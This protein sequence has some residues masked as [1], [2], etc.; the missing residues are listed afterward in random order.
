MI[1]LYLACDSRDLLSSKREFE[2]IHKKQT[3][4]SWLPLSGEVISLNDHN[5]IN[6]YED[7]ESKAY[8]RVSGWFIYKG[9]LNDTESLFIDLIKNNSEALK[10]ISGGVFAALFSLGN[11]YFIFN[12]PM[13]LSN[14]FY[15]NDGANIY[16]SPT[17]TVFERGDFFLQNDPLTTSILHKVGYLFGDYTKYKNIKRMPPGSML[18]CTGVITSYIDLL[19][20][21]R[22]ALQEL[23]GYFN[24]L[25]SKFPLSQRHIAITGGLDSRL[26]LS[27]GKFEFG[28]CYGPVNSA[29]RPIAREF[30][31]DF[32]RFEEFEFSSVKQNGCELSLYDEINETPSSQIKP[33]FVA[34]YRFAKELSPSTNVMFDGYLGGA[35]QRG[36]WL[37]LGG[38]LGELYR[39][40]PYLYTLRK[41]SAKYIFSR[42]YK[43]LSDEEF[44]LLYNDFCEKTAALSLDGYAKVTYYEFLWGRGARFI[45]NGALLLNGQFRTIVPVFAM[46]VVFNSL[47]QE[48]FS[49]TIR[50]KTIGKVW[51]R[52]GDKYKR[53]KFESGYKVSTA[54]FLKPKIA[55]IWRLLARYI[56]GFGNYGNS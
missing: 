31:S 15:L 54:N 36:A 35:L 39:F 22:V 17:I 32:N 23:P 33:E 27:A 45:N 7:E 25:I 4:P 12:D 46:P 14:H 24:E 34:A 50:Y 13:G 42:R 41:V 3:L 43:S 48:K 10:G 2:T 26:I 51:E 20:E 53:V 9:K 11:D 8:L 29:D 47:V 21:K 52:V 49:R 44:S 37:H 28:Y 6:S 16:L 18:S 56:P 38:I 1:G 30:K 55:L 40:F 19:N 5:D